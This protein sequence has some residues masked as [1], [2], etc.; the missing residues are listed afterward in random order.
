MRMTLL[1][2]VAVTGLAVSAPFSAHAQSAEA[3]ALLSRWLAAQNGGDFAGYQALYA[4]RFTGIRRSGNRTVMLDRGGWLKDRGRMFKKPM[5]VGADAVTAAGAPGGERLRFTQTWASGTYEDVGP[6]ELLL[7]HEGGA[8]RIAREELLSSQLAARPARPSAGTAAE[9]LLYV[10]GGELVVTRDV[11]ESWATG[12]TRLDD[13]GSAGPWWVASRAVDLKK[14]PPE[15][16]AWAGKKVRLFGGK[17][18]CEATVDGTMRIVSR[19][20]PHFGTV[21]TWRTD[22][23]S[24]KRI[25]EQLWQVGDGTVLS[26]S[27]SGGCDA[28]FARAAILPG[29][30]LGDA[31]D[32]DAKLS[33]QA[34]AQ[35][36]RLPAAQEAQKEFA[37]RA[38][39]KGQKWDN[40]A[41][42]H[43]L[44]SGGA[45]PHT[46][47]QVSAEAGDE[48]GGHLELSV[49]YELGAD[50][51][52]TLR[53]APDAT[54]PALTGVA[55][56]DG[57][58][59]AELLYGEGNL[60]GYLQRSGEL[61]APGDELRV[62]DYDCPC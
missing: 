20:R 29:N 2:L 15:L 35:F 13:D 55:D 57:D 19:Q 52:L 58:G 26:A 49:L 10:V 56:V 11:V 41:V 9:R 62:P 32:A 39:S 38:E 17:K 18:S 31:A 51:K 33:A 16:A 28:V 61:Y 42:V 47:V 43:V 23:L 46:L 14:L 53:S 45:H 40:D 8:V 4:S 59:E 44:R 34:L 30:D 25:A 24:K 50:G 22:K 5:K 54:L 3:S 12:P 27:L 1:P 7:I 60:R 48:C 6:K 21:E 36:R 37:A